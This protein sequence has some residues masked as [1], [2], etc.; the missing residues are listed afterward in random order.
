MDWTELG[1]WSEYSKIL[2]AVFALVSPPIVIPLFMGVVAGRPMAEKRK[3]AIAGA[4]GFGITMWV[5]IFFGGALLDLFGITLAAFRIAGGFLLLLIALEMMRSELPD[6]TADTDQTA[7]TGAFAAGIVPLAIPILAGPGAISSVVIFANIHDSFE[8]RILVAAVIL[9]LVAYLMILLNI[10]TFTEKLIGPNATI[11]FN[12]V[13][14]LV[15]CAIAFE[16]ILDG[17]A[18]HFP[19]LQTIH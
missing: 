6:N 11:I 3:A 9:T 12:K 14:G 15:I 5:F 7:K 17:I 13:M 4:I 10:I 8:H 18:G 16:F 2:V 1:N 19:Q